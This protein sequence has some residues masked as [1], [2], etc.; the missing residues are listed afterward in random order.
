MYPMDVQL[1]SPPIRHHG[2]VIVSL[3][4]GTVIYKQGT[5]ARTTPQIN[6]GRKNFFC[7][8]FEEYGIAILCRLDLMAKT[9][10]PA[11]AVIGIAPGKNIHE[12]IN[13][14]IIH[15]PG[16]VVIDFHLS[17]V[18][19]YPHNTSTQH[20]QFRT[21]SVYRFMK[22]KIS[23]GYINPSVDSKTDT[24]GGMVSASFLNVIDI[25]N[26][27]DQRFGSP[28][29]HTI[30]VFVFKYYQ[31]HSGRKAIIT[32]YSME[33]K[34][35]IPHDHNASGVIHFGK[36]CVGIHYPVV[37]AVHQ[38]DDAPL[39]GILAQRTNHIHPNI[40]FARWG[41]SQCRRAGYQI[42]ARKSCNF[43]ILRPV[44]ARGQGINKGQ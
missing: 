37:V 44:Q 23:Y 13:C 7:E 3:W 31:I 36:F 32:K 39:T 38:P 10:V 1:A 35:L 24:I 42:R 26:M 5:G 33:H 22:A 17:P 34:Y 16:S 41:D 14:Q 40:Y 12:R 19:P 6:H 28:I 15:I 30:L 4:P 43:Q 8:V 2:H 25:T 20:R 9:D 18:R 11:T 29:G 21:F 27:L